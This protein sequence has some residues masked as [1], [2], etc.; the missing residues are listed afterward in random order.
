MSRTNPNTLFASQAPSASSS[1]SATPRL[2]PV[3]KA[4]AFDPAAV[5]HAKDRA[6]EL[7]AQGKLAE[8]LAAFQEVVRAAP[9]EPIYRQKVAEVLQRLGRTQEAIAE[10]ESA[11]ETWART[12]WLVRAIALCKVILQLDPGHTRTQTLLANLHARREQPRAVAARQEPSNATPPGL[13]RRRFPQ[14]LVSAV[15]EEPMA[16][17]PFFTSFGREVFLEVLAGVERRVCQPGEVIVQEG[18]PGRS[19]FIVVEGQVNV[20]RQDETG[21]P[22]TLA[23]LGDGEF[24]GELALLCS[25]PRLSTVV[26][27]T[28]TVL[29]E[30]SRERMEAISARYPQ[31]EEVVQRLYRQRLLANAL[32]S[33]PL[34]AN[35]PEDLRQLVSEAFSPISVQAGEEILSRGQPAHALYLLLRGRCAAIHQHVDGRETPYPEM[36][37]GDVFGEI[38]LL[39]SKL[40]TATVRATTSCVLLKLD[41]TILDELLPRHP[42][43]QKELQR[44]GSERMLR[45]SLLLSG[46]PIH[47]GDM[48]V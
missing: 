44:L 43:L 31:M 6:T 29:L 41:G 13:V 38:S 30:F 48:R 19:M 14:A 16:P 28:E 24:F 20:V 21:Q 46:R 39:R 15:P 8:A 47:L 34:F 2:A 4:E 9:G 36:V 26:A 5:R 42:M 17:V 18:E 7:L 23:V 40:A 12:G 1:R 3:K 25:G 22:V 35:W 37:E 11:A 45:T 32:R 33:N 27:G 10:Y